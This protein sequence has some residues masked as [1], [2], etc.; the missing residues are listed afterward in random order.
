MKAGSPV[1]LSEKHSAQLPI[2]PLGILFAFIF[3][4]FS[5][6]FPRSLAFLQISGVPHSPYPVLSSLPTA[7]SAPPPTS[8]QSSLS[9]PTCSSSAPPLKSL[10]SLTAPLLG[11]TCLSLAS[12]PPGSPINLSPTHISPCNLK[13]VLKKLQCSSPHKQVEG[14]ANSTPWH[15]GLTLSQLC[16]QPQPT[17]YPPLPRMWC[18]SPRPLHPCPPGKL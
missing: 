3:C 12:L 7:F 18:S 6:L 15:F 8:P 11:S 10:P 9:T 5:D 16:S 4:L 17:Y 14:P 2:P 13:L 1:W